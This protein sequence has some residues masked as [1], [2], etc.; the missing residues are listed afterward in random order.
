MGVYT[1]LY[2][3][4]KVRLPQRLRNYPVVI[5]FLPA[6]GYK[7]ENWVKFKRLTFN[8]VVLY[9]GQ[10]N[11]KKRFGTII[12]GYNIDGFRVVLVSK[13]NGATQSIARED[14]DNG[15]YYYK[16]SDPNIGNIVNWQMMKKN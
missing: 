7:I 2:D 11:E 12:G 4:A 10:G 13:A 16:A 1:I 15:D 9:S 6:K 14:L 5:D 3:E 8:G